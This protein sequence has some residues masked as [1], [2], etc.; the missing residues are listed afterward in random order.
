[1]SG[2][3]S[4]FFSIFSK[5]FAWTK[6]ASFDWLYVIYNTQH[7]QDTESFPSLVS[8]FAQNDMLLS[9]SGDSQSN[10]NEGKHACLFL[11]RSHLGNETNVKKGIMMHHNNVLLQFITLTFL[12]M[13]HLQKMMILDHN[14]IKECTSQCILPIQ[15]QGLWKPPLS[16]VGICKKEHK[17]S[18]RALLTLKG[19]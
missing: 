4:N 15:V 8:F 19:S 18:K 1:M 16:F 2:T 11:R 5:T 10:S 6:V 9:I 17:R 12:G 14:Y 7:I 13:L 3:I